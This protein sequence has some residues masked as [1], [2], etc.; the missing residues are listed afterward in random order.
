MQA[1]VRPCLEL[2]R[3]QC[4]PQR[5]HVCALQAIEKEEMISSAPETLLKTD[6][7][8]RDRCPSPAGFWQTA[9]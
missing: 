7:D 4:V 3:V 2:L 9:G 1:T 8:S 6:V 5:S